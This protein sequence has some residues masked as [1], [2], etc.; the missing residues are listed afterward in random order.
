MNVQTEVARPRAGEPAQRVEIVVGID[1]SPGSAAALRWAVDHAARG[2]MNL[3]LVHAWQLSAVATAALASGAGSYVEAAQA[4]ARARATRWV[5][6]TLGEKASGVQWVL[7]VREGGAGP[8][9]TEVGSDAGLIVVGTHEHTG[10][11]RILS[12]SVSHYV[13]SHAT[14]P[15]VAVPAP[16]GPGPSRGGAE[17]RVPAVGP[18]F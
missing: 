2:G 15:V 16:T 14:V 1:L 7:D 8:V 18:L 5:R 10:V 17:W 4:D 6:D 9:V 12:G 13:L 11:R 3:R